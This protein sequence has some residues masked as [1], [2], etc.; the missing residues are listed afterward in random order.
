MLARLRT[1]RWRSVSGATGALP[2]AEVARELVDAQVA[3]APGDVRE[4]AA[5]A[6]P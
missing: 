5:Y 6:H 3:V 1:A 4:R 2:D